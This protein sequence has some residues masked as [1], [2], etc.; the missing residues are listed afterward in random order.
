M[1]LWVVTELL[2]FGALEIFYQS[3]ER[4]VRET[5]LHALYGDN[6]KDRYKIANDSN[7][8]LSW[9]SSCVCLRNICAHSGRFYHRPFTK[10]PKFP[11]EFKLE[12]ER[13]KQVD[14]NGKECKGDKDLLW[15][16]VLALQF[17]YPN[18][19]EWNE[20]IVPQIKA[21]LEKFA[22]EIGNSRLRS[23][24]GFP[25]DWEYWLRFWRTIP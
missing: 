24:I 1:P 18:Q 4:T 12:S 8:F 14:T 15:G 19:D 21:L 3:W 20:L 25:D 7:R 5:L 9:L 2:E 23:A 6:N 13:K 11:E 16:A 17:L 22:P 10:L